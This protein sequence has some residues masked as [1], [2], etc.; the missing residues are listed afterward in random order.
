MDIAYKSKLLEKV[1]SSSKVARKKYGQNM[2]VKLQMRIFEVRSARDFDE[3]SRWRIGGCHPLEGKRKGQYAMT[4]EQPYRLIL[5]KKGKEIE[6]A[7]VSEI[8]DYH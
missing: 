4:L 2:A 1:C 5:N 8:V 7:L 6:M 3:L